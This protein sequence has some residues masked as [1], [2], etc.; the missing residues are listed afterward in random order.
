MNIFTSYCKSIQLRETFYGSVKSDLRSN[1]RGTFLV[2][3][4]DLFQNFKLNPNGF[5]VGYMMRYSLVLRDWLN[6]YYRVYTR[7][8]TYDKISNI[9]IT[10][11]SHLIWFRTQ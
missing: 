2:Q 7:F 10:Y 8:W 11:F 1:V 5:Y 9:F 3:E 4:M 6:A